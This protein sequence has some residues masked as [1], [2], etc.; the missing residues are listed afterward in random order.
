M[1]ETTIEEEKTAESI[2]LIEESKLRVL[3]S[4]E[5]LKLKSRSFYKP[6]ALLEFAKA[7]A[8]AQAVHRPSD[9]QASDRDPRV[10]DR[11]RRA[12]ILP[13]TEVHEADQGPQEAVC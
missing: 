3:T 1:P 12:D 10:E 4:D 13:G 9:D 8:E 7:P 5:L 6:I 11:D 2:R